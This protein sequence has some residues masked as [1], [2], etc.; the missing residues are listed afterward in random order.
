MNITDGIAIYA[1]II[2]TVSLAWNIIEN[3]RPSISVELMP[4]MNE[5]E[6]GFLI[7]IK[8]NSTFSI[9]INNA[10]LLIEYRK[11][12]LKEKL[13]ELMKYRRWKH[14]GM[15]HMHLS[16]NIKHRLPITI[17]RQRSH[18]IE[19]GAAYIQ[20]AHGRNYYSKIVDFKLDLD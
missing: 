19:I 5:N 9:E 7:F 4:Y 11:P 10:G 2:A 18:R 16:D 20:D 15:A 14:I 12:T 1:A 3:K 6:F 8:N 13:V 17:D